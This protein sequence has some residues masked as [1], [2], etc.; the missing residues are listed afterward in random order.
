MDLRFKTFLQNDNHELQINQTMK[1]RIISSLP[2]HE[3]LEKLYREDKNAFTDAF[4]HIAEDNDSELVRFWKLRLEPEIPIPA[5]ALFRTDLLVA[6]VVAAIVALGVLL[7]SFFGGMDRDLF[8]ARNLALLVMAGLTA[9]TLWQRKSGDLRSLLVIALPILALAVYLN[10]LPRPQT[11]TSIL[12]FIHAPL[13]LWCLFGLAWL[14]RDFRNSG[15]VYAFIRYNGELV[16]MTGLI[17]IAGGILSAMTISLFAMLGMDIAEFYMENI[18][19]AGA[20]VSP[21]VAAWLIRQFPAVTG[22]VVPVIARVFTPLVLISAVVYLVAILVSG[23]RISENRDLLVM[24]N[25]MLLAVM[26]IIVFSVTEPGHSKV[27]NLSLLMLL[28]LVIVTL[29]IN[30]VALTAIVTRLTEGFTP[31]RTVVLLSNLVIF[32]H[33]L[34]L[35]PGLWSVCFRQQPSGRVEKAVTGYLPVYFFYTLFVMI[36]VPLLW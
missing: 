19:L 20:A 25:L 15:K 1:N 32:I 36:I 13:F 26:A 4:P 27:R 18:A 6:A 8:Y 11:D 7:P 16:T 30:V 3:A 21:V 29:V 12:V 5:G 35:V 14:G 34:L 9:Y 23:V 22:K 17:L 10:L 24:F 28:L 2:D 31:N 33:L